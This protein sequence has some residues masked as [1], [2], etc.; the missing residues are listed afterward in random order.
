MKLIITLIYSIL[1]ILS[2]STVT[3]QNFDALADKVVDKDIAGIE[4][5]LSDGIDI[6]TKQPSTGATV[7]MLA[8]SYQDFEDVV[9]FL[10]DHG[11]D[12][13]AKSDDGKTPLT[14]AASNSI[15]N[16]RLLIARGADV[17]HAANDGMTPFIQSVFGVLSNKVSTDICTVLLES[18]ADINATL[19]SRAALGWSALHFA[20]INGDTQLVDFLVRHGANVNQ[21]TNEGSSPLYLAKMEDDDEIIAILKRAG[22]LE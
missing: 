3:A 18:G 16:V 5:L 2:S 19:T 12:V 8:C 21:V 6:N 7:L 9:R 14:W 17:N 22:A 11:A 13:N 15:E 1:F 20:V 10:I 4:N